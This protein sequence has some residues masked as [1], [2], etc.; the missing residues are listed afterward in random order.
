MWSL[1]LAVPFLLW[2]SVKLARTAQAWADPPTRSRVVAT[3][4]S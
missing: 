4:A 2:S 3:V 1:L